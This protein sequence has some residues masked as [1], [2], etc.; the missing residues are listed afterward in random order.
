MPAKSEDE[1]LADLADLVLNVGRLIRA[2]TPTG[3]EVV[4][5]TETERQVMR[6]VDL[7]PGCTPSDIASRGRLQRTNVSTALGSLEAKGMVERAT[8][9]GRNIAV[10]PT[11]LAA[12]NLQVLRSAWAAQLG[13]ALHDDLDE[14]RQC[15]E[16]LAR[17]EDRLTSPREN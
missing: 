7:H 10:H 6:L 11:E 15:N 4:P 14:I 1:L 16:V 17:V 2:R 3:P 9:G 13:D 8:A 12:T 5:L